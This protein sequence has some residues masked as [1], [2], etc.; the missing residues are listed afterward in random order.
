M[1]QRCT[2]QIIEPYL[3]M[4]ML[5]LVKH[6]IRR[7]VYDDPIQVELNRIEC[8]ALWSR[9]EVTMATVWQLWRD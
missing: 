5:Q 2:E 1:A 9:R 8:A 3:L 4:Q 6:A 7:P